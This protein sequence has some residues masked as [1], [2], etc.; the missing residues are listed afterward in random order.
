MSFPRSQQ[1]TRHWISGSAGPSQRWAEAIQPSS[2]CAH[3][4]FSG[5]AELLM[6]TGAMVR[7]SPQSL[8]WARGAVKARRSTGKDHQ[9]CLTLVYPDSWLQTTLLGLDGEL[10]P[11]LRPVL[12]PPFKPAALFGRPLTDTDR[13]WAATSMAPHLCEEARK[14]LEAARLTDFF[15][16]EVFAQS[17]ADDP[18]QLLSRTERLARERV[19]RAKAEFLKHLDETPTLE[20]VAAVAGCSPHYLSRTF[21]HVEGTPIV[22]WL[23]KVRIEQAAKLLA[24]GQCN[25]SE[26]ALEVGYRSLSHFS[27]AFAEE[28]GVSPSKWVAHLGNQHS[29]TVKNPK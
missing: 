8:I 16:H 18:G 21:S 4:N 22:L 13:H 17:S 29:S 7:L 26:A 5:E 15:V 25:V 19:E 2:L 14:L 1:P 23:R 28:K 20:E 27:R 10:S 3:L 24:I 6:T 12:L 9:E 11:A